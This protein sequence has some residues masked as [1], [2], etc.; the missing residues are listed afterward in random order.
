MTVKDWLQ[1]NQINL[2]P[3]QV[4]AI[5]ALV[6]KTASDSKLNIMRMGCG[7]GKTTMLEFYERYC[8]EEMSPVQGV[9]N[10]FLTE[11]MRRNLRKGI[12]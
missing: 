10:P 8:R 11:P 3:Y 6:E 9:P 5:E 7:V 12:V 4:D 2:T 1:K